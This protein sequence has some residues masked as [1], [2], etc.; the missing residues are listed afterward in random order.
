VAGAFGVCLIGQAQAFTYYFSGVSG[1]NGQA[2]S[3]SAQFTFS[4]TS[5]TIVLTNT[6]AA[7]AND[8]ANVLDA[9]CFDIAGTPVFSNGN[10]ALTAGSNLVKKNDN[11][12]QSGNAFNTEWMFN[13]KSADI[14]ANPLAHDTS[15]GTPINTKYGISA[16]GWP[17]F[18]TNAQTFSKVFHGVN[19]TAG[20]ND[21]YGIVPTGG[22][23]AGNT[24]NLYA[25][26]SMT[27]TFDLDS[28]ISVR[29]LSNV[30][31][32]YGSGGSTVLTPEP[33]TMAILG[34]GAFGLIR[35]RKRA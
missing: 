8:G 22:I 29:D 10:A 35:R 15:V 23:T 12:S 28:E 3:A 32:S 25:R 6:A 2:L 11:S 16:T 30:T 1:S 27:F 5:L 17:H 20:A 7:A 4:G 9:L 24:S 34:L 31:V 26:D 13:G 21:D 33:A 19:A 14:D 18:T